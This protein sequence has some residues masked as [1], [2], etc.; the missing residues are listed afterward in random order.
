MV[1]TLP[2]I[3][4]DLKHRLDLRTLINFVILSCLVKRL[5][6]IPNKVMNQHFLIL[7]KCQL[8]ISYISCLM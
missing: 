3:F 4:S 5:A 6:N 7:K 2:L 8:Y 1:I